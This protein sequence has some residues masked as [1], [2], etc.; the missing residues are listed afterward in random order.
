M[1]TFRSRILGLIALV[2]LFLSYSI[3][4]YLAPHH[5]EI[6]ANTLAQEGKLIWQK[7]N[8][9]SCHQLYGLGG[10]LG[11]DLTNVL[12]KRTEAHLRA[13]LTSG[14][15]VMPNFNLTEHEKD[16]LLEF[17]KYS[18]STGES[19]PTTFKINLDGTIEK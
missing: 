11:P 2:I 19:N 10:H 7:K 3:Y 4:L 15:K 5:E 6:P 12:S 17:L 1:R 18:N 13:F 9:V 16:A 14:T 8:C